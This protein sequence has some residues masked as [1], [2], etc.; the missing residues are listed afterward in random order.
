MTYYV[1]QFQI[2][3]LFFFAESTSTLT[4]QIYLLYGRQIRSTSIEKLASMKVYRLNNTKSIFDEIE[5]FVLF[6]K[7]NIKSNY[8]K[9]IGFI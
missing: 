1:R 7:L 5:H 6:L 2:A 8:L 3:H 4:A 9:A